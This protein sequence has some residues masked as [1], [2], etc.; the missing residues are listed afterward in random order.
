MKNKN[1]ALPNLS[2]LFPHLIDA[3]ALPNDL[4]NEKRTA[5]NPP[6]Y[7]AKCINQDHARGLAVLNY[8]RPFDIPLINE[9]RRLRTSL[10][11]AAY[12]L[13]S[14]VKLHNGYDGVSRTTRPAPW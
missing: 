3:H 11:L 12:D 4:G 1:K 9:M 8:M 13:P 2:Y 7:E 5:T 6:W 14:E 10:Y